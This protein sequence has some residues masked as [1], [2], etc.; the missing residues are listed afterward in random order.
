MKLD[1][2]FLIDIEA[3]DML[4]PSN[5][6]PSKLA[7]DSE[8]EKTFRQVIGQKAVDVLWSNEYGGICIL[9]ESGDVIASSLG[10]CWIA[11][12]LFKHAEFSF[13]RAKSIW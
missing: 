3:E 8:H 10:C 5:I 6:Q 9:V 12:F 1:N 13:A 11:P 4:E 2:G 7:R